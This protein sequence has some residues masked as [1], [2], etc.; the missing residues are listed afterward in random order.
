[1]GRYVRVRGAG[2]TVEVKG[3]ALTAYRRNRFRTHPDVHY[4][5]PL[6]SR[7]I[8]RQVKYTEED[9]DDDLQKCISYLASACVEYDSNY[10]ETWSS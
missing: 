1:M 3:R 9:S 4:K 8:E 2:W 7:A 10:G 5:K 6:Q